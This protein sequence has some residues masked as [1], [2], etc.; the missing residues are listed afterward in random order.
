MCLGSVGDSTCFTGTSFGCHIHPIVQQSNSMVCAM[1]NTIF[2][3]FVKCLL[4]SFRTIL[5]PNI[6]QLWQQ[7][8]GAQYSFIRGSFNLVKV[9]HLHRNISHL[10]NHDI[11]GNE[12]P[13]VLKTGIIACDSSYLYVLNNIGLFKVCV[14]TVGGEFG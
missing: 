5:P 11:N 10:H 4:C 9:A 6:Q 1:S 13:H 12:H 14:L 8:A 7:I 3:C 2:A